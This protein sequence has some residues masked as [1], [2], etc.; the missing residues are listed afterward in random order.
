MEKRELNITFGKSG[1]GSS[2]TKLS[3]PITWIKKMKISPED[4]ALEVIFDEENNTILI[5]KKV[6]LNRGE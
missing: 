6:D 3:I 5:Q 2:T 4:R 1:S